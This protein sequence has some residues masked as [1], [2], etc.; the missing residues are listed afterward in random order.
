MR[1]TKT[2]TLCWDCIKGA[3]ECCFMKRLQPV[4]NWNAKKVLCEGSLTY[5]VISCPDFKPMREIMT[6]GRR[7][8]VRCVETGKVY[9]S[10]RQC[11]DDLN[12]NRSFISN[13]LRGGGK[14]KRGYHFERVECK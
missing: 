3:N 6:E 11:A 8:M 4:P 2:G 7:T 1:E 5:H 14:T 13:R 9:K 12:I 10:I